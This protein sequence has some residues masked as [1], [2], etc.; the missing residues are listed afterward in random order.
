M[1][2]HI[3]CLQ[4]Y[5]ANCRFRSWAKWSRAGIFDVD[6]CSNCF[7]NPIL[8]YISLWFIKYSKS[9]E[10][11]LLWESIQNI[12]IV[13]QLTLSEALL[14]MWLFLLSDLHL[15]SAISST[16]PIISKARHRVRHA[17]MSVLRF[18]SAEK[19]S[20]KQQITFPELWPQV[21]R[22]VHYTSISRIADRGSRII[23]ELHSPF[24]EMTIPLAY[25]W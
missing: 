3:Y 22:W 16:N 5:H 17:N 23:A 19:E 14:K 13:L 4:I 24:S 20:Y 10:I 8:R 2:Y 1:H 12:S 25:H 18:G 6:F 11:H 15:D 7:R 21:P 9:L